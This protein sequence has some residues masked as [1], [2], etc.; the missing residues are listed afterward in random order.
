MR[1]HVYD[2][3]VCAAVILAAALLLVFPL[4]NNIKSSSDTVTITVDGETIATLPLSRDTSF[5]CPNG[6]T[7]AIEN[8]TARISHSPCPDRLCVKTGRLTKNG[9]TAV[10]L[11]CKTVVKIE[12]HKVSEVDGI[13]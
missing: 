4:F 6:V 12:S 10:C 11:P 3:A 13:V 2:M 8:G 9:Q 7:V 1:K 5:T